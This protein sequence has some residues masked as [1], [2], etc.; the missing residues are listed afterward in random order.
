M[1]SQPSTLARGYTAA[2]LAAAILSTTAVFIRHL[3]QTYAIPAL[4][5]AFW[6]DVFV[7]L[8]LLPIL[9]LSRPDLL[10][11]ERRHFGYML[12][13]GFVLAIFN[14]LWTLSVALNGAAVAT[15]LVYCSAAFTA[16]LGWWLLK[17]SL[18][19][20]KILAVALC[21]GGCVLVAEAYDAAMWSAN[22][23][24]ILTGVLAGLGYAVY[25]LMG[26]SAS[27]RGLNPWTTLLYTF[28]FATLFLLIINLLPG[29]SIPGAAVQPADLLW[30]G[31]SLPAWAILIVLAAGPTVLGF[32]AINVSLTLLPSSVANLLLTSEPVFTALIAFVL[33]GERLSGV[34]IAGSLVIL[35]GVVC[36]RVYDG[37]LASGKKRGQKSVIDDHSHNRPLEDGG[38][39][40][41]PDR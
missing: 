4:V 10:R 31:N 12:A 30:L 16:L 21:L 28:A 13:Y 5:L 20:V 41:Q 3:T 9:K 22:L 33:L 15:V 32:G 7:V 6:R 37:W 40:I 24:G 8:T 19:W 2:L 26:R 17:E 11:L 25:S 27:Q 18:G 36:L 38:I 34:Q 39:Q 23:I 1:K 14:A 29:S 35:S